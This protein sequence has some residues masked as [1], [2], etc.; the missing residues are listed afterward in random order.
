MM[1]LNP[2]TSQGKKKGGLNASEDASAK[3]G[4]DNKMNKHLLQLILTKLRSDKSN[5][6]QNPT[7]L[8]TQRIS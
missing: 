5:S 7:S 6:H 3:P 1:E 2:K 4:V 8:N